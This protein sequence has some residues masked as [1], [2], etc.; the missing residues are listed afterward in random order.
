MDSKDKKHIAIAS[1]LIVAMTYFGVNFTNE[2]F[3][4]QREGYKENVALETIKALKE[5]NPNY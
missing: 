5:V 3:K 4:S 1:V 2:Y